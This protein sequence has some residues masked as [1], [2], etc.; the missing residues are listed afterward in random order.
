MKNID[1]VVVTY[2]RLGLLKECVDALLSQKDNLSNIFIF[3]NHS[4]DGTDKYLNELSNDSLFIIRNSKENLGGAK[5]FETITKLAAEIGKG[6]YIWLMDDDTIPTHNASVFLQKAAGLLDNNFG[7]LCSNVRWTSGEAT[8]IPKAARDWPDKLNLKLVKVEN[9]TFVSIF[10]RRAMVVKVG[11]PLGEMVIWGDDTE[12]TTR[13]SHNVRSYMVINSIV[14]HKTPHNLSNDTIANISKDRIW[15]YRCMSRNLIYIDKKI[16]F[17]G[18][19]YKTNSCG[20]P[21]RF[22]LF[23]SEIK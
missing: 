15:R 8:N 1:V 21:R 14:I 10:I 16:L 11:L 22:F 13:L 5:G 4:T 2:N 23:N 7:F 6:D 17:Y 18:K 19:S 3:N 9:A 20:H 12:Y